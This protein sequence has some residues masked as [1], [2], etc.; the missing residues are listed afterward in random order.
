MEKKLLL[1]VGIVLM[2]CT[3]LFVGV[4]ICM[5]DIRD[6]LSDRSSDYTYE[7]SVISLV[8]NKEA[9]DK[10]GDKHDM[11][12]V[13][14]KNVEMESLSYNNDF[15]NK[16]FELRIKGV[17]Y[18]YPHDFP[19]KGSNIDRVSDITFK[20][21]SRIGA[22]QFDLNEMVETEVTVEDNAVFLDFYL[23]KEKYSSVIVI[24]PGFG[25]NEL[26]FA[27][28]GIY[29]KNINLSIAK[30]LYEELIKYPD[31][32]VYM[33][34]IDD[35]DLSEKSRVDFTKEIEADIIVSIRQNSTASGRTS[36]IRG[37]EI[38]YLS[39]DESGKS[40]R[41]ATNILEKLVSALNSENKGVVA[42]DENYIISNSD[43]IC[44][45][46]KIGYMTNKNEL[47]KL[48]DEKYQDKCAIALKEAIMGYLNENSNSNR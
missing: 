30:K 24:D 35:V 3:A 26:G 23:V 13:F 2:L 7:E 12:L 46:A 48:V 1:L 34:R 44:A 27:N 15:V 8:E 5:P 16:K 9:I 47:N 41:F 43:C 10:A 36:D 33:T 42:G 19:I 28:E 39:S 25:G 37:T 38:L 17:G 6:R 32:G 11:Q 14:P 21:G 40:K 22:F 20:N 18:K 29:E 4:S 31:I 45:I